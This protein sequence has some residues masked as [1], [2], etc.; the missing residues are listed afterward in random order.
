MGNL[1]FYRYYRAWAEDI[2]PEVMDKLF[3]MKDGFM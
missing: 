3:G 1:G 2:M